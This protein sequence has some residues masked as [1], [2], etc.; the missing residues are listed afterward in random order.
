MLGKPAQR[1]ALQIT[2][3][4]DSSPHFLVMTSWR[5]LNMEAWCPCEKFVTAYQTTRYHD[6]QDDNIN[7]HNSEIPKITETWILWHVYWKPELWSQQRQPLIGNGSVNT[8]VARQW[9]SSRHVIAA[10]DTHA[11]IVEILDAVFSVRS[12]PRFYKEDQLELQGLVRGSEG[13][14][15]VKSCSCEKWEVGCWSRGQFENPK[16]EE[17]PQLEEATKQRLMKTV[18]ENTSL[19]VIM[20]CKV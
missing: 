20:I 6:I 18:T 4:L 10:T 15:S 11:T 14:Q 1:Q 17:C 16:E 12:V 5:A 13:R 3:G 9:L 2:L 7:F 8:S 19:C